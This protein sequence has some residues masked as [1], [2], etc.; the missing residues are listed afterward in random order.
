MSRLLMSSDPVPQPDIEIK[1]QR[2]NNSCH[3][4]L[5]CITPD[6]S[7]NYTWYRGSGTP[8]KEFQGAV[9]EITMTPQNHSFYTCQ[10][11]NPVSHKNKT[12]YLTD[13]LYCKMGK[14]CPSG[15]SGGAG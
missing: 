3:L 5:S 7:L 12:I 1:A 13:H 9:L 6:Q 4:V 11:S 14:K 8:L 10:V 2:I 15:C